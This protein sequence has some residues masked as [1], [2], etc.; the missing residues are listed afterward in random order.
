[1]T[2]RKPIPKHSPTPLTGA[3]R[4][5]RKPRGAGGGRGDLSIGEII[6]T[7]A[8]LARR[9]TFTKLS[10]RELA[11]ALGVQPPAIY[12]HIPNRQALLDLTAESI[13]R[14][15]PQPDTALP[16]RERL[17]QLV[18]GLRDTFM[19]YPDLGRYM[20][21]RPACIANAHWYQMHLKILRDAGFSREVS[22]RAMAT[23]QCYVNPLNM[24][25]ET[26]LAAAQG[27]DHGAA[28]QRHIAGH[29]DEYRELAEVL[30]LLPDVPFQ[31]LYEIGLNRVIESLALDAGLC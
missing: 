14:E 29:P 26:D 19:E 22:V 25:D 12:Y 9:H 21:C 2:T 18:L 15:V 10:M 6:D 30:P 20:L 7:A 24:L 13:M 31:T 27:F 4:A 16:W 17:R 3:P 8:R 5:V 23:L 28:W 1:M 11:Q